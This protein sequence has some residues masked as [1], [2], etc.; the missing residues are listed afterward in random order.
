M[1]AAMGDPFYERR[2]PGEVGFVGLG[3]MGTPL[4][5]HLVDAGW[6]VVGHDLSEDAVGE[7]A[8]R[9]GSPATSAADVADRVDVVVTSL[10]S[11]AALVAVIDALGSADRTGRAPL[12]VIE[13]STLQ[14]EAK[15]AAREQASALGL[16]LLDCTLSGTSQQA[17]DRDVIAYLSGT[18]DATS[19]PAR[20]VLADMVRATYEV[21]AYGAG[22]RLKLVANL[23]V[24]VHNLTAAE[25][26]LLAQRSGLDLELAL[27]ALVD[28]AGGSKMLQHRG[29]LMLD[30]GYRTAAARVDIFLKDIAA[31]RSLAHD[32]GS[33]IPLLSL[34]GVFY[35]AAAAQGRA[36][37]DAAS[38]F[39]VLDQMST[40]PVV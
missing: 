35:E 27:P 31:I 18:D 20:R 29:P 22:T 25:A 6:Q 24:A 23:L 32:S 2:P 7:L 21:G 37:Q 13:T 14:L 26:L 28:G 36:A 19:A 34:T 8:R 30:E 11:A 33:P 9:G 5:G 15:L 1:S 4:A 39:A 12:V 17:R 40:P 3:A 16:A 38:V 10:P